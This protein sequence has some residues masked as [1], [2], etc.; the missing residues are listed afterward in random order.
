M[1]AEIIAFPRQLRVV[2]SP[3]ADAAAP[4]HADQK[5]DAAA[6]IDHDGRAYDLADLIRH[7]SPA[8]LREVGSTAPRSAQGLW[9]EVVRRWPALTAEIVAGNQPTG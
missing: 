2:T 6:V 9:D 5:D 1:T 4:S 8:E 7:L 3:A